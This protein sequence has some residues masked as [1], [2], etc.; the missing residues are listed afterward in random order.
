METITRSRGP[1][2]LHKLA[3]V[4]LL[5]LPTLDGLTDLQV[6]GYTC[7]WC[8]VMLTPATA[9]NLGERRHR[10][11]G[12]CYSTY[13]RGCCSC[14]A[15]RAHRALLDHGGS[16]EQCVDDG[17]LCPTGRALYRLVRQGRR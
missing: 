3:P 5:P 12:G 2:T 8:G 6:R 9:V 1:L 16:C 15:D 11:L 7:I 14:T 13:P 4:H 17:A 10:R